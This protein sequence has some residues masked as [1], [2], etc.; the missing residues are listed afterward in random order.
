MRL[1]TALA[2]W[3]ALCI[4]ALAQQGVI[5]GP[6]PTVTGQATTGQIPATA[7]SDD[8]ASGK[9]GEYQ[10]ANNGAGTALTSAVVTNLTSISLTAGD[11]DVWG[12]TTTAASSSLTS[13]RLSTSSISATHSFVGGLMGPFVGDSGANTTL[14]TGIGRYSLSGTTTIYLVTTQVF[15]GTNTSQGAIYARRRR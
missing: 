12:S 9:V 14:T 8:A 6:L 2:L 13:V 3:L 11:W 10:T 5:I 7:T 1:R 4:P 15:V